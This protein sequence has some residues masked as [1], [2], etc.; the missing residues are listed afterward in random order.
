[1]PILAQEPRLD[2][3][4]QALAAR[5]LRVRA[6]S[7]ALIDGLS[8]ED[9]LAQSMPDASPAKW[10]L[11]HTTWFWDALL[12]EPSGWTERPDW[13]WMFNSYYESLGD[14]PPRPERGLLTRPG[15]AQVLDW[16]QM[17]TQAVLGLLPHCSLDLLDLATLGIAHEEQHQE[18]MLTD[19][20]HLFSRNPLRPALRPG[21]ARASAEPPPLEWWTSPGGV[22]SLGQSGP[23]FAFDNEKPRHAVALRPFRLATR[24]MTNAEYAR[25]VQAGGY[26]DP[27]FWLSDG[28]AMVQAQS[29][30]APLYWQPD[31]RQAFG[32]RGLAPLD[33]NAPVAHLSYYEADAFARW[34]GKRLPTEAEWEVA[35]TTAP[36]LPQLFG[37]RWQWTASA[38][39]PYPGFEP[40][41]GPAGEYNGKFMVGQ[42]VLRGSSD[43][44]PD[45]HAR[46]TYRNFFPPAAR[47]QR[48]GLRLAEDSP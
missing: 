46:A 27:R 13:A 15:L 8:A 43:L 5:F 29:W 28:W 1:M 21:P 34:A 32:P 14:R 42:M 9:C 16:R 30:T 31:G 41:G 47:W 26:R 17:V 18:L 20:L 3:N 40:L 39:L 6:A 36:G 44:T 35:A 19:L 11:A 7:E 38:Y 24:L 22:L 48:S 45:G 25:F 2:L 4:R 12:L 10:H 37:Q 33:W 23:G